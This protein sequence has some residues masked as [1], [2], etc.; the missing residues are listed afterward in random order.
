MWTG[1]VVDI[2]HRGVVDDTGLPLETRYQILSAEET[3][4][5]HEVEYQLEVFEY[6]INYRIGLW[7]D[8]DAPDYE[9]ATDEEKFTGAWWADEDGKIDGDPGFNWT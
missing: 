1:D 7:M 3:T 6:S 8:E 9:D 4:P 5:G 2:L